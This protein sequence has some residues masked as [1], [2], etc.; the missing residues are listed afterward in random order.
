VSKCRA[1]DL[2]NVKFKAEGKKETGNKTNQNNIGVNMY[3][4]KRQNEQKQISRGQTDMQ[5]GIHL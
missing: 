1:V 5:I 3:V 2:W 4:N